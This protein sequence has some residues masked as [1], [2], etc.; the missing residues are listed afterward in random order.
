MNRLS[1]I[2]IRAGHAANYAWQ[3]VGITAV[4]IV[5]TDLTA[6]IL[7]HAPRSTDALGA[8]HA[9]LQADRGARWAG[10]LYREESHLSAIW[11][12]YVYWRSGPYQGRY[13]NVRSNGLRFTANNAS[14][15]PGS[16]SKPLKLFM[17]GGSTMFGLG[18]RD[19]HTIPSLLAAMLRRDGVKTVEITN[20]GQIG[21]VSTQEVIELS[22]QLRR[23]DV[24]NLVIFYD[25]INDAAASYQDGVAGVPQNEFN[26]AREFDLLNG[27]N[28]ARRRALYAAAGTT[29]LNHTALGELARVLG[30]RYARR[31]FSHIQNRLPYNRMKVGMRIQR[32][33]DLDNDS[34][35]LPKETVAVYLENMRLVEAEGKRFGFAGLFYWQPV[36]YSKPH[37]SE[38]EKKIEQTSYRSAPGLKQFVRET[39]FHARS[40]TER[41]HS[42]RVHDISRIFDDT[43]GTCFVDLFHIT[44][45]CNALVAARMEKDVLP[46]VSRLEAQAT[47]PHHF[48]S[49]SL[50]K[51]TR[52][53]TLRTRPIS[54]AKGRKG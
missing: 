5:L 54:P 34:A 25:G 14:A 45:H 18:A 35:A 47:G 23:G 43:T 22:E 46:L 40:I 30:A 7:L 16:S 33:W 27:A 21:Y 51:R 11:Y 41:V 48:Q 26:R 19:D 52:V 49:L 12:P 8:A 3:L 31:L 20:Y 1:A 38:I 4:L 44:G 10:E 2:L 37:Q 15:N 13:I 50:K 17:F 29:F 9:Q 36:L 24:P 6:A 28:P 42:P 32:N 53:H 39:Y